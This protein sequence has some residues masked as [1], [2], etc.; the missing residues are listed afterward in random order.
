MAVEQYPRAVV[1]CTKLVPLSECPPIQ[2][3]KYILPKPIKSHHVP[4]EHADALP[5][6]GVA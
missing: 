1:D 5:K 6:A 4:R 2:T 3:A